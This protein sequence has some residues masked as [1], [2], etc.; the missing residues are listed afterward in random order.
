LERE[1]IACHAGHVAEARWYIE[2]LTLGPALPHESPGDVEAVRFLL[3]RFRGRITP[4]IRRET[5]LIAHALVDAKR[6]AVRRLVEALCRRPLP[7][8]L[9]DPVLTRLIEIVR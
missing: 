2:E 4:S 8:T 6:D 5:R 7:V 9:T 3:G 1:L